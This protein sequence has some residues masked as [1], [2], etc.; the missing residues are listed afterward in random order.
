MLVKPMDKLAIYDDS[1][2]DDTV[3]WRYFKFRRFMPVLEGRFW[4]SRPFRFDDRWEG[5]FPPSYLRQTRRYADSKGIPHE[6]F[7]LEFRKRLQRHR[8]GHFVNCWHISDDESDA[9]WKIYAPRKM[10]V[11]IQS[12]VGDINNCLRPHRSGR[13]I[14][15]DPSH[16]VLSPTIFGPADILFKRSCFSWEQ[17]YRFWFD[18]EELLQAIEAGKEVAEASLSSGSTFEISD[19]PQLIQRIVVAPGAADKFIK[20]VQ[21]K[22]A[23]HRKSWL[24]NRVE[25]SYSDRM[26]D[27]FSR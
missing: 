2:P 13:V 27:S 10:G 15:Y 25:R 14:Y 16:E 1:V 9:M 3:I 7:A 11:A 4:F 12:T 26:W 5:L 6:E 22:C 8:F 19:M 21:A 24:S 23:E 20:S 17:E 18:D